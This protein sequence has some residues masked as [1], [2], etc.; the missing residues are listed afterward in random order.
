TPAFSR[1]HW[2]WVWTQLETYIRVAENTDIA[3]TR[4][5]LARIPR[6]H[7]EQTIKLVMN[8]TYD[9]YIKSGKKWD[10]FLQ[11]LRTIHLP[12][13]LVYNRISP[14]GN[15]TIIYS[16]IGAAIFII[17]LS[18]VNFMNLSTAQFM[19]RIKEASIRKILG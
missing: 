14:P 8:K 11:P 4:E 7:A 18:C 10:L 3:K 13:E 1:M 2:S 19:R 12:E 9:E 16:L 6:K 15:I 17:L 5:T